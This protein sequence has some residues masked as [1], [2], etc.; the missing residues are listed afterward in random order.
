MFD[1]DFDG[2]VGKN[3]KNTLVRQKQHKRV[4]SRAR[5][6]RPLSW[7][8]HRTDPVI[9]TF[10]IFRIQIETKFELFSFCPT[11]SINTRKIYYDTIPFWN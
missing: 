3:M 6:P 1:A 2:L 9:Q 5:F 10:E 11:I 4:Q 7:F 8:A